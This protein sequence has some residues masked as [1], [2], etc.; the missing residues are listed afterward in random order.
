MKDKALDAKTKETLLK[1]SQLKKE[2]KD[3]EADIE[4]AS[5]LYQNTD[6]LIY[7]LVSQIDQKEFYYGKLNYLID[8]CEKH[9][10]F[11]ICGFF[12]LVMEIIDAVEENFNRKM[13][14][15]ANEDETAP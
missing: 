6:V 10:R 4:M 14:E 13:N 15:N 11:E 8:L 3:D 2:G 1:V 9:E 5:L 12:K 7:L